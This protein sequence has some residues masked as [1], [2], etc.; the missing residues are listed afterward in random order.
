LARHDESAVTADGFISPAHP[1]TSDDFAYL[2]ES[3]PAG[4]GVML[5]V[6]D[7]SAITS[8]AGKNYLLRDPVMLPGAD[9][10]DRPLFNYGRPVDKEMIDTLLQHGVRTITVTGH[11][12]PVSYELGTSRMIAIIFL[13]L[14]AA[15]KPVLWDPFLVMLEKR[16][17]ELELGAEAERLNA[18][19]LTRFEE[20]KQRRNAKLAREIQELKLKNQREATAAANA[21]IKE[22]RDE[23]KQ[24]KTAG[25]NRINQAELKAGRQLQS[26]VPELAE[27]IASALTPGQGGPRWDR[28]ADDGREDR[29]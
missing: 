25:L 27:M 3:A 29:D 4:Q 5:D 20:E 18:A 1:L 19:E 16:R 9:I 14:V 8:L 21:I 17:H 15:L 28:M 11:G 26:E 7:T 12:V 2:V 24:V 22:A 23:G 10:R 6:R 13:T